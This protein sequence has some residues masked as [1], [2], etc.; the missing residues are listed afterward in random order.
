MIKKR[1]KHTIAFILF[2]AISASV[3]WTCFFIYRK[4]F[5][6]PDKFGY[7]IPLELDENFY[8]ALILIPIYWIVIYFLAGHYKEIWHRSRIEEISKV[9]SVT[10]IGVL[11]LFFTLLLDDEVRSYQSYYKTTLVLFVLHFTLTLL[12]R[13]IQATFVINKLKKQNIGFNTIVVG[14]NQR[15]LLLVKELLKPNAQGFIIKGFVSFNGD[16][17]NHILKDVIPM[18][19]NYEDLPFLIKKFDIEE[20]IIG[21]ESTK[22]YELNKVTNL[23]ED[24]KVSLK[25]IPDL[26]DMMSGQVKLNNIVGTALISIN[27]DVMPQWQKATKRAIDVLVSLLVLIA[28]MPVFIAVAVAVKFSSKGPVFFK[29]IRLGY[30]GKPFHIYK[31]RT[32][33]VDAEAEGPQLSSKNDK[34]ITP[35]GRWLRKYRLDELPQF[36]NV[37]IGEM[38]LVGPRPERKFFVDQIVKLAPHY[39]H[40]H[41]V[42]PGITSWGQ[43]K[44]GY[45]ES[46]E[47]MVERL[48]YDILYIENR[49]IAVD[50]RILIYTI[51]TILQGAGR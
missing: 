51:K 34:R 30:K 47:Q 8:R 46:V 27:H 40:L 11:L 9:F 33:V 6:E 21:I 50:F 14:N 32:M 26:Y 7:Q 45:A 5:I 22:H 44:Y 12:N 39:K 2:D 10:I 13:I 18:L 17:E 49:S 43:V 23:L 28:F 42:K 16:K 19:G 29:Q 35:V 4:F 36:F 41:R 37:L 25:I 1:I 38:S 3:A 20:V 48:Q 15:S 24:E 31:F